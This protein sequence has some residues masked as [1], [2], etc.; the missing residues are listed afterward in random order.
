MAVVIWDAIYF[1]LLLFGYLANQQSRV[2]KSHCVAPLSLVFVHIIGY[3]LQEFNIGPEY[4]QNHL[5]N[6]GAVAIVP[7]SFIASI[8]ITL[9]GLRPWE[10]RNEIAK[11]IILKYE[12][13]LY[14]VSCLACIILEI[15]QVTVFRQKAL[16]MGYSG[17]FDFIDSICYVLG[18]LI[19][20][21]NHYAH[22]KKLR[23]LT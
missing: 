2:L 1:L 8:T 20:V 12:I 14:S 5:H 18:F 21:V 23:S 16:A 4:V 9:W 11:K 6:L 13:P 10:S 3:A 17:D 19:V 22:K 7:M 15:M